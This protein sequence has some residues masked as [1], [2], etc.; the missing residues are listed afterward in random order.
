MKYTL[1]CH[2]V[3]F[4][5]PVRIKLGKLLKVPVEN[6]NKPKYFCAAEAKFGLVE[7]MLILWYGG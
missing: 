7:L 1:L 2:H 4:V 6:D 5:W 3:K